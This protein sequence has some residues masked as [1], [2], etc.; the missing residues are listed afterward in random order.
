MNELT[1]EHFDALC[2]EGPVRTQ[3]HGIEDNRKAA[4]KQF[5]M[6]LGVCL[7]AGI[8]LPFLL[9]DISEVVAIIVFFLFVIGGLIWAWGPLDRARQALKLPV[10]EALAE[11]GGMTYEPS[12]FVPPVFADACRTIF[13]TW[14]SSTIFT[15]LFYGQDAAGSNFA[16]YEALLTRRVGK[17]STTVFQGQIYALQ[18]QNGGTGLTVILPDK[19]IFNFFK[20]GSDMERVHFEQH[21]EFEKRFEVYSTVPTEAKMLLGSRTLQDQLLEARG[22][23][24]GSRLFAYLSPT[25]A[26]IAINGK[27]RF[28][29]GSM[30]RSRP[31]EERVR[32]MFDEVCSSLTVMKRLKEAFG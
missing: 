28:E 19:G 21:P 29:P 17:N 31:G 25:D 23:A 5:W 10:L 27:D 7:A 15:D 20:P 26:F 16:F 1:A 8:L 24:W 13:G 3:I 2:R 12:N 4:V 14:L 22:E 11:R 6:R 30:F 18:R 9:W 32:K